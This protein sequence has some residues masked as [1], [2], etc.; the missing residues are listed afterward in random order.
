MQILFELKGSSLSQVD[1]LVLLDEGVFEMQNW[2]KRFCSRLEE[3]KRLEQTL[4]GSDR[5]LRASRRR[6]G[7]RERDPDWTESSWSHTQSIAFTHCSGEP[8]ALQGPTRWGPV[9]RPRL[10]PSGAL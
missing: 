3:K 5:L 7:E 1:R 10:Q 2:M 4:L 9:V 6:E 8:T